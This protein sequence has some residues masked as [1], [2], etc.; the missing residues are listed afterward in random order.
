MWKW[1][2]IVLGAMPRRFVSSVGRFIRSSVG[3]CVPA[4]LWVSR[5]MIPWLC[6]RCG[7]V[8]RGTVVVV[9]VL[10]HGFTAGVVVG[11]CKV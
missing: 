11:G 2:E 9:N 3:E 6:V 7:V 5:V 1:S 8:K 4:A 10:R